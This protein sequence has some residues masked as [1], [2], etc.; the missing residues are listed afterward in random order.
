MPIIMLFRKLFG[1]KPESKNVEPAIIENEPELIDPRTMLAPRRGGV[2]IRR[3][4]SEIQR[5][6]S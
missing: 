2:D 4:M 6:S 5:K 1:K 3:S